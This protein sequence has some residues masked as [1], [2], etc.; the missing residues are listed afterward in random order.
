MTQETDQPR[1]EQPDQKLGLSTE[2]QERLCTVVDELVRGEREA[3]ERDFAEM[4]A[5]ADELFRRKVSFEATR[6]DTR[7]MLAEILFSRLRRGF[8]EL[9]ERPEAKDEIKAAEWVMGALFSTVAI[10]DFSTAL[11]KA[12]HRGA[13]PREYSFAGLADFISLEEVLQL[14]GGGNHRGCL[15]LE[16][17]DNRLDI[18]LNCGHIAYYDPHHLTRRILPV[19]NNMSY[20]EISPELLEDVE[21]RHAKEGVPIFIGL[22]DK[23]FLKANELRDVIRMLGAEIL[24]EFLREQDLVAFFYK[25]MDRLPSFAT[26]MDL[27]MSV[28]PLLLEG[29]RRQDDWKKMMKVF[30]DPDEAVQPGKDMYARISS[31]NLGVHEIKMLAH[32]NGESSPRNLA[33]LMGMPLIDVYQTLVRFATEGVVV[34]PPEGIAELPEVNMSVEESMEVAFQALDANDD[35]RSLTL[36]LDKVLGDL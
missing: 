23:G 29:S 17:H 25:R 14:L 15:S 24:Y 22:K 31:L 12:M 21:E 28:T 6:N 27:R 18:Y 20:R 16:K 19:N 9:L 11:D 1:T 4:C 8:R 26:E 36:A 13:S 10:N 34:P 2:L 7:D 30:P 32:I 3:A 33:T 5:K 35:G